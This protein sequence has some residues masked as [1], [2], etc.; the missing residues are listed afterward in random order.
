MKAEL[1]DGT[2]SGEVFDIDEMA[3]ELLIND[4]HQT[5]HYHLRG[6]NPN[7]TLEYTHNPHNIVHSLLVINGRLTVG[8]DL[9]QVSARE[10]EVTINRSLLLLGRAVKI[11]SGYSCGRAEHNQITQDKIFAEQLHLVP[12]YGI[13]RGWFL[14]GGVDQVETKNIALLVQLE[15]GSTL[16]LEL[17]KF[18][19][20]IGEILDGKYANIK[21]HQHLEL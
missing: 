14:P 13:V 8:I 21:Q 6:V 2:L 15:G 5:H 9:I 11:L 1:L 18:H 17:T 19:F 16:L 3:A 10:V 12:C 4:G 7:L 20:L